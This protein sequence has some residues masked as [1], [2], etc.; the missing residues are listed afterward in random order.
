MVIG[1][2]NVIFFPFSSNSTDG[3]TITKK[4]IISIENYHTPVTSD[5]LRES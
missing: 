2:Y 1:P 4:N 3:V 5:I